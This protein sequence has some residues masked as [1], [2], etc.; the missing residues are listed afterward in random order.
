MKKLM[1]NFHNFVQLVILLEDLK[2]KTKINKY[3]WLNP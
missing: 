3:Y 1:I 2:N